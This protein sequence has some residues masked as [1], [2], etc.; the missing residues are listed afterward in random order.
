[1]RGLVCVCVCVCMCVRAYVCLILLKYRPTVN[2]PVQQGHAVL[3]VSCLP[4]YQ[5][6]RL[7]C[8]RTVIFKR[9]LF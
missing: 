3:C 8:Y 1:M 4:G 7:Q 2:T 6:Y 9:E 5:G